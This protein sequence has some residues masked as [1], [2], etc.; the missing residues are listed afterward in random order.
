MAKEEL[1]ERT[2]KQGQ[3]VEA[4]CR[5]ATDYWSNLKADLG[6]KCSWPF[7]LAFVLAE[8]Y[9][10]EKERQHDSSFVEH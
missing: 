2:V 4:H 3:Q 9:F 5:M 6:L 1:T 10:I 7:N 8:N